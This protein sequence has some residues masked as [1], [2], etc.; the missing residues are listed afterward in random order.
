MWHLRVNADRREV[1][2]HQKL[3]QLVCALDR[4]DENA[5]LVEIQ[6][7]EQFIELAVLLI[8]LKFHVVL[9]KTVESELCLIVDK[10]LK[11]L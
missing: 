5:D 3:V 10:D 11:R 7:V 1:T 2:F 9:L 8:F 4:L 6:G